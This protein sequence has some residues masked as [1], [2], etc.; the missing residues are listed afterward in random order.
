MAACPL[1]PR[2]DVSPRV[3]S[4]RLDKETHL[5]FLLINLGI[6]AKHKVYPAYAERALAAVS[7]SSCD[8][9]P[10]INPPLN[11][12]PGA[13]IIFPDETCGLE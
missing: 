9:G 8:I 4:G 1:I 11:G 7:S 5:W 10:I 12:D 3:S 13:I 6:F 2:H